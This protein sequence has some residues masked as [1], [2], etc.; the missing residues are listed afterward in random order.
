MKKLNII[1]I[2]LILN[3]SA[4]LSQEDSIGNNK[5]GIF[6]SLSI[7]QFIASFKKLPDVPTCCPNYNNGS[8][9][10][11]NL[12]LLYEIPLPLG[13][14]L[15]LR[16]GFANYNGSFYSYENTL[17][18]LDSVIAQGVFEHVLDVN[19][20]DLFI[21]PYLKISPIKNFSIY[22]GGHF[23][24]FITNTYHQKEVLVQP[25][26][27]GVFVD[28]HTRTRNQI[29]GDIINADGINS[30]IIVGADYALPLNAKGSLMLVPH[31]HYSWGTSDVIKT[32]NW[33]INS[34]YAGASI[35]YTFIDEKLPPLKYQK[36]KSLTIADTLIVESEKIL[37]REF[38]TGQSRY[39]NDEEVLGDTT[40]IYETINRTDTIYKRPLPK[41]EIAMSNDKVIINTQFITEGY[42][43]LPVVFFDP[44]NDK[45]QSNYNI[46]QNADKFNIDNL[47][48]N[49][50]V[51]HYNV[52]NIIGSRLKNDPSQTI[53]LHGY[54]DSIVE[55]GDCALAQRR[56]ETV[57]KYFTDVWKIEPSRIN[58]KLKGKICSP[59]NVTS[60]LSDS[61]YKENMRV[62]ISTESK[63]ILSSVLRKRAL[64]ILSINPKTLSF[65]PEG[66]TKY[67]VKEWYYSLSAGDS[68]QLL[69]KNGTGTPETASLELTLEEANKIKNER[70]LDLE[71]GIV[72][73]EGKVANV[74]RAIE[75][76]VDTSN[77]EF[78]RLSLILFAFNS[79]KVPE[80]A[81]SDLKS[82]LTGVNQTSKMKISGYTDF[83]GT[84]EYNL[85]LSNRRAQNTA[86]MV[87]QYAPNAEIT[88]ISGFG[89][90]KFPPGLT[91]YSSPVERFLSRTVQVEIYRPRDKK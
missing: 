45:L 25:S 74:K 10:G 85:E 58:F 49:P 57:K 72:D 88:E 34:M 2:I 1:L 46:L 12:G 40:I 11:F 64:Q 61:G 84:S 75:V 62:E 42:P 38:K 19:L 13:L 43:V 90:S 78:Q 59:Q 44:M 53:T 47:E 82:F 22:A 89:F 3:A 68:Q 7:H 87:K 51:F 83:L 29:S 77:Y 26:D 71:F 31:F 37:K 63:K 5:Y 4:L 56:A 80:E 91:Q 28:T 17:V 81:H 32:L 8:G 30:A 21:E 60:A 86:Q 41:A 50:I 48:L 36:T 18:K 35:K 67:G 66:S 70:Y 23:G 33:K 69:F 27:R 65:N 52:M 15:G 54:A 39:F 24:T 9:K 20:N 73:T 16:T 79:D 6:G 55:K 14:S 76:V